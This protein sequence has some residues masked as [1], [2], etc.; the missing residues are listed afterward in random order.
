V[1]RK[2]VCY[3]SDLQ[4]LRGARPNRNISCSL[5]SQV[6][7]GTKDSPQA[8]EMIIRDLELSSGVCRTTYRGRL[9]DLDVH[10]R[11]FLLRSFAREER[12]EVHDW[13]VSD[14]LVSSEWARDLFRIFPEC[15]FTAS[16]LTLYLVEVRHGNREA[17]IF[18]PNGVPL[19]YVFPPFVVSFN[20]RDSIVLFANRLVRIRAQRCAKSLQRIV[21][22]YHWAGF[23]DPTEYSVPP[24]RIRILPLVHPEA[25]LLHRQVP[26]FRIVL[27]SVL[28]PLLE[29]VH[30]IRS[31]NIYHR[32]YFADADI[33]KGAQAVFDS[34]VLGGM[35][36]LGRTA[37][38]RKPVR[39]EASIL[40]KTQAG[41]RVLSR[42][43]GGSE[44]EESLTRWGFI[45][46]EDCLGPRSCESGSS[47]C[48]HT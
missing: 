29:R 47:T 21:S 7:V 42:L 28:T 38:E 10:V 31:M 45:D 35:W 14:A 2:G 24:D 44:L 9:Q 16:D 15:H 36:I 6:A 26:H 48:L 12:I 46:H 39:N 3:V 27:H 5:V 43:N 17:C 32:R 22:Q 25:R 18:E 41:F 20:R 33:A 13:A 8:F 34:L 40:R 19:Q 30:V 4:S 11:S 23:D 37:E 1:F